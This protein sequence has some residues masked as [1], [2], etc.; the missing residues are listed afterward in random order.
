MSDFTTRPELVGHHGM[1]ASTHWLASQSG[2]AVLEAGG[3]AFDAAVAAGFVLHV[4]EPHLN[5]PGGDLPV[6]AW[7]AAAGRPLV[8][9][10]QGPAPAAASLDAFADLGLDLVP[11]TGLLPACVPGSFGAWLLML[12]DHGTMRLREVL[13]YA[14]GYARH[15]FPVVPG[16]AQTIETVTDLFT[17]HW[18][19]SRDVWLAGGRAPA[20]GSRMT[21]PDLAATFERILGEAEAASTDRD[22]QI[23]AARGCFYEGFVAEAVADLYD[24]EAMDVSGRPHRGLLRYEDLAGWRASVEEP[25]SFEH[26]ATT[27]LKVGPWSQGPAFLQQLALLE[28][29][30]LAALDTTSPDFVHLL[31]EAAKLAFADREAWYGDPAHVD[32]PLDALLSSSY[33]EGRRSL[34]SDRAVT[35]GLHPG[36]P[37]GREPRL[38]SPRE[39]EQ[40]G[41]GSGRRRT[42][43]VDVRGDP[44]RHL[45]P[46][47]RRP[48]G[49]PGLGHAQRRV[50]AELASG[51]G[52]RLLPVHAGADVLAGARPAQLARP[53]QAPAHHPLPVAGTARR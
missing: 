41:A 3:N 18:H 6:I 9:C 31:T 1:V 12:R 15:G 2:M 50:A 20:V 24:G 47:R 16:I 42:H 44:R 49:Q 52:A 28:G 43:R 25:V 26:A 8:F 23:E 39:P 45:P 40:R 51:A 22:E 32:V 29:T 21:N 53:R 34:L 46:R 13:H 35:E 37:D 11:G 4:V 17:D 14:I 5:G 38:P 27:V 7:S 48:L 33:A 10:G 36:S 30:D 19:T